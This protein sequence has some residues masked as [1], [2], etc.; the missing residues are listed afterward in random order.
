MHFNQAKLG[1]T[2][3]E[4]LVVVLIIGI[5][6]AVAL[7]QY[8]KAV[9]KARFTQ[10]LIFHRAIVN[11][12]K[13]FYLANGKYATTMEELDIDIQNTSNVKCLARYN[14][15]RRN[16]CNMNDNKGTSMIALLEDF[17]SGVF[18]CY[19]YYSTQFQGDS[20]CSEVTG[21]SNY[22]VGCDSGCHI[23]TKN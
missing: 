18:E 10:M 3:I 5:L 15:E 4:L 8:Q 13:T 7:P 20:L 6:A 19:S 12:Q 1:F 2:L 16:I 11:A 17:S 9:A 23:Y 22:V 14:T 21:I